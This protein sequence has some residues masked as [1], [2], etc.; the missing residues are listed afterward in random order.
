[1]SKKTSESIFSGSADASIEEKP[2]T[3]VDESQIEDSAFP[4]GLK[5]KSEPEQP[6]LIKR[7]RNT[8]FNYDRLHPKV[9]EKFNKDQVWV[10][11][12]FQNH[13]CPNGCLEFSASSYGD[14]EHHLMYDGCTYTVRKWVADHLNKNCKE[15]RYSDEPMKVG[16]I[17]PGG[18]HRDLK[19]M[20]LV[21]GGKSRFSFAVEEFINP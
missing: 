19:Y 17:G 18:G 16:Q 4:Q 6:S 14:I 2:I 11:G 12:T 8:A 9:K 1:M 21:G 15:V 3:V 7:D 5:I 13:E 20:P 10:R